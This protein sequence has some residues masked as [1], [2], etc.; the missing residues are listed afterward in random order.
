MTPRPYY[1][2]QHSRYREPPVPDV[3]AQTTILRERRE[4]C[5]TDPQFCR[6]WAYSLLTLSAIVV[7]KQEQVSGRLGRTRP[8][9]RKFDQKLRARKIGRAPISTAI[10]IKSGRMLAFLHS[11]IQSLSTVVILPAVDSMQQKRLS[12]NK[13][14]AMAAL[15]T[16]GRE[17]AQKPSPSKH[18]MPITN[19]PAPVR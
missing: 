15:E 11:L 3:K 19:I 9:V 18:S 13:H 1:P 17:I 14:P 8:C 12:R 6:I 2:R 5:S 4:N 7:A 10:P 16:S